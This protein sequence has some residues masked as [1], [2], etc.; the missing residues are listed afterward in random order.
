MAVKPKHRVVTDA[1]MCLAEW[2]EA[3]NRHDK[4]VQETV[5]R[6]NTA[7]ERLLPVTDCDARALVHYRQAAMWA[8]NIGC[9]SAAGTRERQRSV[10]LF[11]S[12]P[13]PAELERG[14]LE[15]LL[16]A[17]LEVWDQ[18][19]PTFPPRPGPRPR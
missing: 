12:T 9:Y 1:Q 6:A 16:G 7:A 15:R 4:A 18:A 10:A 14:L 17:A 8:S 5:Q 19:R 2:W 3:H 11:R 13:R